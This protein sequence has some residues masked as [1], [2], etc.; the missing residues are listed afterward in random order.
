MPS[1]PSC[2]TSTSSARSSRARSGRASTTSTIRSPRRTTDRVRREHDA[3]RLH[4]A[5]A[6][7]AARAGGRRPRPGRCRSHGHARHG[8]PSPGR[9]HLPHRRHFGPRAGQLLQLVPQSRDIR[10]Q[11]KPGPR[12]W[13]EQ[14]GRARRGPSARRQAATAPWVGRDGGSGLGRPVL[15]ERGARGQLVEASGRHRLSG[16]GGWV[17]GWVAGMVTGGECGGA[18]TVGVGAGFLAARGEGDEGVVHRVT[19]QCATR[20]AGAPCAPRAH[21]HGA[22]PHGLRPMRHIDIQTIKTRADNPGEES[23]GFS[24]HLTPHTLTQSHTSAAEERKKQ[25]R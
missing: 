13:Q 20:V 25:R 9:P 24:H 12:G 16:H 3:R 18:R 6:A 17:G 19:R 10:G 23:G 15:R 8:R 22:R 4:S 5:E 11:Q 14:D 21:A 7:A 2:S 1:A